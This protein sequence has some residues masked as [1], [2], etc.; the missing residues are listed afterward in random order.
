MVCAFPRKLNVPPVPQRRP[1]VD[2]FSPFKRSLPGR[3][4][5]SGRFFWCGRSPTPRMSRRPSQA[6]LRGSRAL[7]RL[8]RAPSVQWQ[9]RTC[10]R[11][12]AAVGGGGVRVVRS[13]WTRLEEAPA[14]FCCAT[15]MSSLWTHGVCTRSLGSRGVDSDRGW[16]QV[17][18]TWGAAGVGVWHR[19]IRPRPNAR[20]L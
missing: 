14:F 8:P 12:R 17:A 2:L 20:I 7:A 13:L 4:A 19:P 16:G 15:T 18:Y 5:Y 11:N 1:H 6:P 10:P 9:H 3:S